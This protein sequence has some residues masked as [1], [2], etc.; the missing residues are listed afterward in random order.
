M[1]CC[2]LQKNFLSNFMR[3]C[4]LLISF[5]SQLHFPPLTVTHG[6]PP[7]SGPLLHNNGYTWHPAHFRASTAQQ[8]LHT[9]PR[10]SQGLHCTTTVTHG[11]LPTSGPLLHNNSYTRHPTHFRASTKQQQLH[12][13]PHPFQ[14]LY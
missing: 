10:P 2:H 11:T 7:I 13:S 14:G 4:V 12:T 9:V 6:T 8:Q 1:S 3:A 5:C